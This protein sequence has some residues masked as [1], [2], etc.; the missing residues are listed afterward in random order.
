MMIFPLYY[1][2]LYYFSD[3]TKRVF[4][5]L[6][7]LVVNSYF[8]TFYFL[9]IFMSFFF[10][11]FVGHT[12]PCNTGIYAAVKPLQMTWTSSLHVCLSARNLGPLIYTTCIAASNSS[13]PLFK[14]LLACPS[15]S[16]VLCCIIVVS[17]GRWFV[18]HSARVEDHHL[19]FEDSNNKFTRKKNKN[20]QGEFTPI[21]KSINKSRTNVFDNN[22]NQLMRLKRKWSYTY[23]KTCLFNFPKKNN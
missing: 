18:M 16:L 7:L 4:F 21:G 3:T 6:L 12:T 23:K 22:N 9:Y 10:W 5:F 17:L 15:C 11:R 14:W 20:I 13:G 2:Y 19:T 8:T 1:I